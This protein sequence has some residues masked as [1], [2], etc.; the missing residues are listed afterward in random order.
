[1][2]DN[3]EDGETINLD[4]HFDFDNF[5]QDDSNKEPVEEIDDSFCVRFVLRIYDEPFC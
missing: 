3:V 5:A 4:D 2:P 1:M